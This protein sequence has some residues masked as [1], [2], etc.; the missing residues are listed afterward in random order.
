MRA[1]GMYIDQQI[2]FN[3]IFHTVGRPYWIRHFE[4]QIISYWINHLWIWK[5]IPYIWTQW[6]KK[7][8]NV[9]LLQNSNLFLILTSFSYLVYAVMP[10]IQFCLL[11]W[12]RKLFNLKAHAFR[13]TFN[14][15]ITN[16]LKLWIF[17]AERF[18]I[19]HK[20]DTRKFALWLINNESIFDS[21]SLRYGVGNIQISASTQL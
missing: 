18:K 12:R 5:T 3:Y 14:F 21:L 2:E 19:N 8:L 10:V 4:C 20:N 9:Q 6:P 1:I 13:N 11:S 16:F 15:F 17:V 7:S